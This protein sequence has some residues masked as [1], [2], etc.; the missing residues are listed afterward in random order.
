MKLKLFIL[1]IVTFSSNTIWAQSKKVTMRIEKLNTKLVM[2][3]S[4]MFFDKNSPYAFSFTYTEPKDFGFEFLMNINGLTSMT[5][6]EVKK[7]FIPEAIVEVSD[8]PNIEYHT[9]S[10]TLKLNNLEFWTEH[11]SYREMP[12]FG[13]K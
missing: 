12:Y 10:S 7:I 4:N 1:L 11:Q 2:D 3:T 13:E 5:M 6:N 8:K 9:D